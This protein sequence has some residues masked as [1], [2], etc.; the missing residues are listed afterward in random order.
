M[1]PT[2]H[3]VSFRARP[4]LTDPVAIYAP[5]TPH[6]EDARWYR[7]TFRPPPLDVQPVAPVLPYSDTIQRTSPW[8][9]LSR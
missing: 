8:A 4:L 6:R 3:A 7:P 2:P 1:T 5:Y 9:P